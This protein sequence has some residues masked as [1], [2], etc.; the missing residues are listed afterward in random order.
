[1]KLAFYCNVRVLQF[2][3]YVEIPPK[4]LKQHAIETTQFPKKRSNRY[5]MAFPPFLLQEREEL[6]IF[7]AIYFFNSVS[8]FFKV[9]KCCL[10]FAQ[11]ASDFSEWI[12]SSSSS[13]AVYNSL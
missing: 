1:M 10:M 13:I 3:V 2:R 6:S 9:A 5:Y 4:L 8:L 11:V 12:V 7:D